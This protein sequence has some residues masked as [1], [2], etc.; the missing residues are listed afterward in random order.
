MPTSNDR[1]VL[2]ALLQ[3]RRAGRAPGM[4]EDEF[5]EIFVADQVLREFRLSDSEIDAGHVDGGG[6]GGIDAMYTF[7][8][9]IS[10]L[11]VDDLPDA[12]EP[13]IDLVV[14]QATTTARFAED[15][16]RRLKDSLGDL[17]QLAATARDLR[18]SY[19]SEVVDASRLFCATYLHFAASFPK[20]RIS[21]VYA[22]KGQAPGDNSQLRR[23]AN[24]LCALIQ[25]MFQDADVSFEFFGA[26]EL[27]QLA[28]RQPSLESNVELHQV[29][30]VDSSSYVALVSLTEFNRLVSDANGL[31]A[32][33]FDANVRD[34]EGSVEVNQGIRK[35]LSAEGGE[36]DFWWFNNGVTILVERATLAGQ[37]LTIR[38]PQIVNGLQTSKE[39]SDYLAANPQQDDRTLLTRILVAASE[40]TRDLVIRATNSQTKVS[41]FALRS[42]DPLHRDLEV[43]LRQSGLF[44]ERRK[45]YY[46]NRG[47]DRSKIVTVADMSQAVVAALLLRPDDS[48]ARP[49]SL[50]K[51]NTKYESVFSD[52]YP[53]EM[54]VKAITIQRAVDAF[55]VGRG[56][57][58]AERNNRRFHI[59]T[60]MAVMLGS[61]QD[62]P[63]ALAGVD[64]D[65]IPGHLDEAYEIV[66][67]SL[68]A[69]V[70]A[71]STEDSA[72][73]SPRNTQAL[74]AQLQSREPGLS[75]A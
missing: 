3:E 73:K 19:R 12:S 14:V 45:N 67:Q 63:I 69:A 60:V 26:R 51:D 40:E 54:Y 7:V 21:I 41:V 70:A 31:R 52:T 32:E 27:F 5:F 24:S 11:D 61:S 23:R 35:T 44:Y 59:C 74:L 53:V 37:V 17:L 34:F 58:S 49:S 36:G 50:V 64:L 46:K 33:I 55:L 66:D 22:T 6:D 39:I 28:N 48:R 25:D 18:I 10:A 38:D 47:H 16:V 29:L 72:S 68:S 15:R 71:G 43:F 42:T 20:L 1:A 75:E 8:N 13:T 30:T 56:M 65:G 2:D 4:P 57:T 9:G 62:D